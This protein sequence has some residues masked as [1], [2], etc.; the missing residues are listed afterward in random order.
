MKPNFALGLRICMGYSISRQ[1]RGPQQRK[2]LGRC[3]WHKLALTFYCSVMLTDIVAYGNIGTGE[4]LSSF[5]PRGREDAT[6]SA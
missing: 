1:W 4:D 6:V 2:M 5:I 3:V